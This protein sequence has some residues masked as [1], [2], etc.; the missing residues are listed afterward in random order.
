MSKKPVRIVAFVGPSGVGKS[1]MAWCILDFFLNR[2]GIVLSYTTREFRSTDRPGEYR[3]LNSKVFDLL[4]ERG[5]FFAWHV[6]A[7]NNQYGTTF[8]SLKRAVEGDKVCIIIITPETAK[9]L[10]KLHPEQT[11]FIFFQP[12]DDPEELYRRLVKRGDSPESARKRVEDCKDWFAQSFVSGVPYTYMK[13][14][15]PPEVAFETLKH[16]F[17]GIDGRLR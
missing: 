4:A 11:T 6:G 16:Y 9:I 8:A 2:V 14:D 1:T 17:L 5:L 15:G 3:R 10:Y 7:H 12:P 13:N